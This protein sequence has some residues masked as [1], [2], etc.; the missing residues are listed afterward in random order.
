MPDLESTVR[1]M[2]QR[3]MNDR[4][5]RATLREM[6]LSEPRI[7][8]LIQKAQETG[9][10]PHPSAA[11]HTSATQEK[12]EEGFE[13]V[14]SDEEAGI[15]PESLEIKQEEKDESFL[16]EKQEE[17]P[18]VAYSKPESSRSRE[19]TGSVEEE[20]ARLRNIVEKLNVEILE[21]KAILKGVTDLNKEILQTNR[22]L[23]LELKRK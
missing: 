10:A 15:M 9:S 23:F 19:E 8:D 16:D 2:L 12:K 20:L 18:E 14:L 3:G 13:E 4:V 22:D 6:G 17:L 21:L 5:I 11:T 7:N 1:S